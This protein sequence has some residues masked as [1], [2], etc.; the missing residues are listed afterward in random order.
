MTE[1]VEGEA[2]MVSEF[3]MSDFVPP[4]MTPE[5]ES[6]RTLLAS[7]RVADAIQGAEIVRM[8]QCFDPSM[9]GLC[10]FVTEQGCDPSPWLILRW[11]ADPSRRM[12][13]VVEYPH[14]TLPL[15]LDAALMAV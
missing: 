8:P 15:R 5:A 3:R 6:M 11:P 10:G 13:R 1:R 7:M 2:R 9:F 4:F 14:E 12:V